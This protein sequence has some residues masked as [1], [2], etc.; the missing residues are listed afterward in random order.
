DPRAAGLRKQQSLLL[1]HLHPLAQRR[2]RHVEPKRHFALGQQRLAGAERA[3]EN[4][5]LDVPRRRLSGA[6]SLDRVLH[7]AASRGSPALEF[8]AGA[9]GET[10]L[11]AI[12]PGVKSIY[13]LTQV[14]KL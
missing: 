10:S 4:Q 13:G 11:T 9:S 7:H 2:P 1:E 5:V 12:A 3:L 6:A 14:V 8:G